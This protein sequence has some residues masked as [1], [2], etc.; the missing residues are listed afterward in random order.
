[1]PTVSSILKDYASLSVPDQNAVKSALVSFAYSG[2]DME[3]FVAEER[4]KGGLICPFCGHIYV[5]RN[6]KHDGKQRYRCK[7]CGKTFFATSNSIASGTHKEL[8]TW[9]LYIDCMMNGYSLRKSARVCDIHYNTAFVWR[10]KILDALQPA[11]P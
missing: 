4:F 6:G 2:T 11:F 9:E 1:M 3:H 7:N 5:V 8:H 10:H